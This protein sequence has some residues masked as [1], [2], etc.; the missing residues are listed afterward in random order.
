VKNNVITERGGKVVCLSGTYEGKRP[1]KKIADE[2]E[3]RF[4]PE[5]TLLQDT[6]YNR[7]AGFVDEV[8]E[9]ACGLHHFRLAH[10]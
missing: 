6:G 4:P 9:T 5:S 7:I 8:M 2:E 1:D 10:R 3:P